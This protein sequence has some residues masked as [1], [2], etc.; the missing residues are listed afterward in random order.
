V[1]LRKRKVLYN[2]PEQQEKKKAKLEEK[3]KKKWTDNSYESLSIVL[4]DEKPSV[5]GTIL[6]IF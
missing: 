4:S 3:K 6:S 5:E 1:D 2:D